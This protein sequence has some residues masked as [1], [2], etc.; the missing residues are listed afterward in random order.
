MKLKYIPKRRKKMKKRVLFLLLITLIL[1]TVLFAFTSCD[2][3]EAKTPERETPKTSTVQGGDGD[4]FSERAAVD[5]ELPDYDFDGKKF[6]I[7]SHASSSIVPNE[8]DK[9]K[10]DLIKDAIF[11]RNET[12]ENRFNVEIEI[13]YKGTYDEVCEWVSKNV[14]AGADEFDLFSSHTASAGNLV[15]KDLFLNWYDI[16]N[17]DF[18]KPW[19]AK[20][21]SEELTYD[22]KCVLAISDFTHSATFGAYCIIF[23]KAL[24]NS[25]DFGNLYDVVLDGK[26]TF[27][28][29]YNLVKD[30]YIDQDG[31]GDKS[32]GDFFGYAQ[33]FAYNCAP[34]AWLWAFD[35]PIV[36]KDEDGVPY[37]A[38][39][40]DKI[41]SIVNKIY[42]LCINSK[43]VHFVADNVSP[44]GLDLLINRRAIM[45]IATI[46]APTGEGLRNFEDDYGILP[47]PKWDENQKDYLTMTSGEHTCLAVPKTVKDTAFVGACIEAL[48][49]EAY[50]FLT[51]FL[52]DAYTTSDTYTE[53]SVWITAE[54]L[55]SFLKRKATT[56]SPSI[57]RATLR[58]E[59][60]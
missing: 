13:A 43:G 16:P 51:S 4:I 58:Q 59:T 47:L 41:N 10:G 46:S 53:P 5:D 35:N 55:V 52:T 22:G 54:C 28:Y 25:Y 21:C 23:N 27:D 33:H 29:F 12:V 3:E 18:T 20:S 7:A 40:T 60:T 26:W 37:I 31:S 50:R 42:D 39:K 17:V 48:S 15:L 8:E 56:L 44:Q 57:S 1:S 14:L 9:N 32:D 2:K 11:S 30:V 38:F 49:A 6:R 34:N 24:A 45:A 19:W 36:K